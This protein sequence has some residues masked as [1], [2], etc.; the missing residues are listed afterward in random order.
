MRSR[1]ISFAVL[2][3]LV[4]IALCLTVSGWDETGA[5]AATRNTARLAVAFFL[6]G[7]ASP[8]LLK[9]V[10]GWPEQSILL[11]MFVGAQ[12]VHFGAVVLLH[13][14]FAK[15]GLQLG[16][17]QVI[18]VLVGFLIVAGVGWAPVPQPGKSLRAAIHIVLLHL[19]FLILVADYAQHPARSMRWMLVPLT[20]A[21]VLRHL[22]RKKMHSMMTSTPT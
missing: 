10:N 1:L 15:G 8:G 3:N 2:S 20:L 13:T 17:P 18:I 9:W 14:V 19:I 21:F 6:L 7:F 22:P 5:G 4:V 11:H 16:I 12:F